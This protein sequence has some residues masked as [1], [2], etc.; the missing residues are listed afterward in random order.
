MAQEQGLTEFGL[1]EATQ[2]SRTEPGALG[3]YRDDMEIYRRAASKDKELVV[4]EG[5]S[6]YDLYD[7]PEPVKIALD[8]MVPSSSSASERTPRDA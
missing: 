1:F 4:G 5:F 3:G 6:H 7:Q 8:P 2:Y